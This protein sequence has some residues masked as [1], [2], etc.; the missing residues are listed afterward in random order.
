MNIKLAATCFAIAVCAMGCTVGFDPGTQA[1]VFSCTD[2]ADCLP[3]FECNAGQ[4]LADG[5]SRC[6]DADGDGYG[7]GD[8]TGC[9]KCLN[10]NQC[11]E[12][13][14][15]NNVAVNPGADD[16]CDGDDNDCDG[17]VDE[18]LPCETGLDCPQ[19]R[20]DTLATCPTGGGFCE[21]RPALTTG[22]VC[23]QPLACNNGVRDPVPAECM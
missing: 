21:H 23:L 15:D 12:D 17:D 4:C 18:P 14:D 9:D 7:V 8:T 10:E 5:P 20:G 13:C 19:E 2:S 1:E 22:P 3:G 11:G 16:V 6:V